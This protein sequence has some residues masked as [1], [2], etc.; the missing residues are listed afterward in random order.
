MSELGTPGALPDSMSEK[1]QSFVDHWQSLRDGSELP[2]SEAFL[3]NADPALQPLISLNDVDPKA[4]TNKVALFGTALVDLWKVD[5]TGREVQQF[6][7]PDQ[8]ERLTTDLFHCT[9]KPCGIWEISSLRTTSGRVIC[10][11]MV[12]L[13]LKQNAK[14][15]S[16]IARYYNILDRPQSGELIEDILHF[17]K[18]EWLDTGSGVPDEAPR[19]KAS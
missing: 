11:E 15:I 2:T 8:A 6:L 18:K 14:G 12:T 3:D 16:R 1:G 4:G 5:L 13:P 9:L 7:A 10:W 17:Y 19:L